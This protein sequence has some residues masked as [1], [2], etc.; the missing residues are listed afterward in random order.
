M[1]FARAVPAGQTSALSSYVSEGSPRG[2]ETWRDT[3]CRPTVKASAA[4]S[5]IPTE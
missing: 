2:I 3:L 1:S 5:L 4:V